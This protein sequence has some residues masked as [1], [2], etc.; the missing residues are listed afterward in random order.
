MDENCGEYIAF[1]ESLPAQSAQ[2][3]SASHA[4][5]SA[6]PKDDGSLTPLQRAISKGLKDRAGEMTENLLAENTDP[7]FIIQSEIIPALDIVGKGFEEKTVYLPQLLMSAEA[8][9][10]FF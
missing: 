6:S 8:A 3:P 2:Q 1:T 4:T 7:L 10:G 9:Q 5:P